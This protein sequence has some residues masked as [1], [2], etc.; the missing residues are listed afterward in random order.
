MDRDKVKSG[1]GLLFWGNIVALFTFVPV[2][3]VIALIVGTVME[4][5]GIW[6]LRDQEENYSTAFLLLI[7]G[8]VVGLVAQGDGMFGTVMSWLKSLVSCATT[9]LI[10]T[11]CSNCVAPLSTETADYCISVRSWYV[12]CMIISLAV[13]IVSVIP[14]IGI[15]AVPAAIVVV[16]LQI[17]ASIRYLIMLWKCNG[18]L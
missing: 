10:C 14:L 6:K 17:I 18:V 4:I 15:L 8:F 3:G 16:I 11:G 9:Y 13:S 7:I 1:I 2:L 5:L 12:I